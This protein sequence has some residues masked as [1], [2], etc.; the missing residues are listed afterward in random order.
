MA[1][2]EVEPCSAALAWGIAA[3]ASDRVPATASEPANSAMDRFARIS[4]PFPK[5]AIRVQREFG[6]FTISFAKPAR[7]AESRPVSHVKHPTG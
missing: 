4:T 2:T 3:G 6:D 5:K 1:A 7:R